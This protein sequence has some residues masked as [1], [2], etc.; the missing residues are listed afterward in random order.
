MIYKKTYLQ[1]GLVF[2]ADTPPIIF[3][4]IP[5]WSKILMIYKILYWLL[6]K[7]S[8]YK[9]ISFSQNIIFS[10]KYYLQPDTGNIYKI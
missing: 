4:K 6:P 2:D 1:N 5:Y 7:N 9:K 3:T 10:K 8:I